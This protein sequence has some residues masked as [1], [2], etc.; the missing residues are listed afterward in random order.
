MQHSA[1]LIMLK[2]IKIKH[3]IV[4]QDEWRSLPVLKRIE[5]SLVKGIA[6]FIESD[7]E[8]ILNDYSPKLKIIEGPLMSGMNVVVSYSAQVRC[9]FPR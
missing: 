9:F 7:L 6:D 5:H 2:T 4:A 1:C 3:Q 8:E